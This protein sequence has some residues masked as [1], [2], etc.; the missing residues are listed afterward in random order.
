MARILVVD[1]EKSIRVTLKAFLHNDGYE[2][3][4]ASDVKEA[5]SMLE[6]KLYEVVITDIIMPQFSGIELLEKIREQSDKIQVIVM[7]GEPT[8]DT[9]VRAVQLG[10]Y[11]YISKPIVKATLLKVVGQA[12]HFSYVLKQKE[13]LEQENRRYQE[14]LEQ[15]VEDQT[16]AL[17]QSMQ[18]TILTLGS[19]VNLRDPYTAKH[20]RKVGN[21]AVAIAKELNLSDHT[22][23]GIRVTG[24]LH[25]IGKITIPAEVLAKPGK[26]NQ[27]EFEIIKTHA[28]QGYTI[29]KDIQLPWPVADIVSQHHER[30]DGSGYPSGLKNSQIMMEAHVLSVA[31]V[32]EAMSSHRPYRSSLGI[33]AAL[34]EVEGKAGELYEP[35]VVE[36][37]VNL[38]REKGYE[39]DDD[40]KKT[41]FLLWR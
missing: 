4:T 1:D 14:E 25:D 7:T 28:I 2:V 23:E 3:D 11:D 35:N 17:H 8:L 38:F 22:I 31:D 15:L 32:V 12:A 39:M 5:L 27:L 29:L 30:Y 16:E 36:A 19:L 20:Q 24:Y 9:A 18:S 33:E 21:L 37:C 6:T 26:I 41:N 10:A 13:Q 34:A 40:Y